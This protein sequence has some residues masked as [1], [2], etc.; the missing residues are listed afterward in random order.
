MF[1]PTRAGHIALNVLA[2]LFVVGFLVCLILAGVAYGQNS[3]SDEPTSIGGMP[4]EGFAYF[5]IIGLVATILIVMLQNRG[6]ML[7]QPV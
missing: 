5:A 2:I 7:V 6:G 1:E 3:G 4:A